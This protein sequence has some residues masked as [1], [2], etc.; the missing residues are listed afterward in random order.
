MTPQCLPLLLSL[1]LLTLTAQ[2]AHMCNISAPEVTL[3]QLHWPCNT[4]LKARHS[5]CVAAMHRFCERTTNP[6]KIRSLGVS[7]EI[8]DNRISVSCVKSQRR[9]Y[10]PVKYLRK[11]HKG[12]RSLK[13]SQ[14]RHCLAATHRYC[15]NRY[16]KDFAGISQEVLARRSRFQ[17]H[18][19]KATH[20]ECVPLCVLQNIVPSCK[21]KRSHLSACFSAASRW[22]QKYFGYSGGITQEVTKY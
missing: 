8:G 14:D 6:V 17:V 9:V 19:F 21:S 13:L 20:K 16:G 10:V 7:R 15:K 11:L 3:S 18:C 5:D 12:C 4:A 1:T 22:C 2:L